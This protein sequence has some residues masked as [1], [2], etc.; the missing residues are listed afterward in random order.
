MTRLPDSFQAGIKQNS[1]KKKRQ[2]VEF[3]VF[4]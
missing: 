4:V 3:A 2:F 1:L